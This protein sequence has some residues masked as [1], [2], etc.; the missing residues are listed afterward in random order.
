MKKLL[1]ASLFTALVGI[2]AAAWSALQT[3]TLS[4]SGMT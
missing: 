1:I 2:S 3:V 4:V